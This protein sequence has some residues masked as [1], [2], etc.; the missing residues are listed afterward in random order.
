MPTP[1]LGFNSRAHAGR[2][3]ATTRA[4]ITAARVSIHAPTRGATNASNIGTVSVPVSIHAPTRGATG[5]GMKMSEEKRFN[6]RAHAGRDLP[7]PGCSRR[8]RFQFTRPRG[9]RRLI[10]NGLAR[11]EMFQF[12]RPRGAR[13]TLVLGTDNT[14]AFQFTRPRGARPGSGGH[15]GCRMEFQF[16]RPRG[17]RLRGVGQQAAEEVSIHAPTRGATLSL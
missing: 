17:A 11:P 9:A 5:K 3:S 15:W 6:S 4:A 12:T 16:T 8:P 14:L 2:D 7:P 10:V 13:H 1:L